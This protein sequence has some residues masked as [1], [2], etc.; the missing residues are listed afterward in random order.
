MPARPGLVRADLHSHTMYSPDGVMSP[1]DII[2][3]CLK[4]GI[5][6]LAVTDHNAIAG[7]I[8]VA[9]QAPFPVIV[10]EEVKTSEGEIIGLYLKEAVPKKLSAEETIRLIKEQGGL[11]YVPH[12]FD[13]LHTTPAYGLLARNAANIDIIEVYNPRITFTAFNEQARRLARKY[14]IPGGAGSDCHVLQGVG[15]AMLSLRKFSSPQ[16]LLAS[17]RGA[18]IIRSNKSP[19][20]LHSLKLL[21]NGRDAMGVRPR[22]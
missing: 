13:P 4:A 9:M 20:Y 21:K 5:D 11:V 22:S 3:A 7:A 2:A 10:G 12:P 15:T 8:G 18:D 1:S 19:I 16:E 17:L 14:G 6:C